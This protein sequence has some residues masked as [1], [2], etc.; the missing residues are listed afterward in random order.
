MCKKKDNSNR[1]STN[2]KD[3]KKDDK[4]KQLEPKIENFICARKLIG[5]NFEFNITKGDIQ[6]ED[7][8]AIALPLDYDL[9]FSNEGIT[10]QY[11]KEIFTV[12]DN[13]SQDIDEMDLKVEKAEDFRLPNARIC[14]FC[15]VC[16]YLGDD[17]DEEALESIIDTIFDKL[18]EDKVKKIAFHPQTKIAGSFPIT[19]IAKIMILKLV[20]LI[21]KKVDDPAFQLETASIVCKNHSHARAFVKELEEHDITYGVKFGEGAEE[22]LDEFV[23]VDDDD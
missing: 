10:T 9:K 20:E 1:K 2:S 16:T 8:D 5:Q 14:Y 19:I 22:E 15:F 11:K 23:D 21:N 13:L 7:V 3:N 6:K 4:S 17:A 18:Q 12:V